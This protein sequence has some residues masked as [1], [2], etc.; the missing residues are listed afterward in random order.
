[1]SDPDYAPDVDLLEP[2]DLPDWVQRPAPRTHRVSAVIVSH[3]GAA[4]LPATL[5]TLAAQ[6][7]PPQDVVGVDTGSVDASAVLLAGSLGEERV[8]RLGADVPFGSA[9]RAGVDAL[10]ARASE[11]EPVADDV[12]EWIWLLHD[13]SAPDPACLE[14]LLEG[15]DAH[16]RAAVIGAKALGWHD[17][18]LLF[19]VGFSVTGSGRRHTGLE[20]REHDQGQHDDR[21]A[22]LAVGSAGMLIRR[23]VWQ[24]LDGFDPA[25]PIFRDDLDL[26]WRAYR[27]G[28]EVRVVPA[29]VVHHREASF[30]GR[31]ISAS[32]RT[33]GGDSSRPTRMHRADRRSALHVLLTHTPAWRLPL[34]LLRL[35]LGTGLRALLYLIGKD[36]PRAADELGA[37]AAL[38]SHPG[39]L[40]ASR[41]AAA[42]L[43]EPGS[44]VRDLRP[45]A[46]TMARAAL[47]AMGGMITSSAAAAESGPQD[48]DDFPDDSRPG[49]LRRTLARPGVWLPLLLVAVMLLV[50]RSLWLGQGVLL[51]GAL[52]PAPQGAADLWQAYVA[53]WHE[54]G[55][56]SAVNAPPWIAVLAAAATVLFGKAPLAVDLLVLLASAAAAVSAYLAVRGL[57]ASR[58]V[59]VW[60][61]AAYGLLPAVM[62][63]VATGRLGV[64]G[65][66]ILLPPTM[67]VLAR[68]AG[69]G[70]GLPAA[71]ARTPW[72]AGLL[73]AGLAACAP[74]LWVLAAVVA[75]LASVLWLRRGGGRRIAA[76][77]IA[78]LTP[79]VLLVPW[80]LD[81]LR[82]PALLL[83]EPGLALPGAPA[84]P[85]HLAALDP[86]GGGTPPWLYAGL[87]AVA[88]LCCL[89]IDRARATWGLWAVGL[90]ALALAVAQSRVF[91]E[92]AGAG[93]PVPSW[94]GAT[95]LVLGATCVLVVALTADGL[96][97]RIGGATFGWRQ[98]GALVLAIVAGLTP[99]VAAA[100]Y[101]VGFDGPLRRGS[102]DLL[103]A[104]VAEESSGP[105]QTRSLILGRDASGRITYTVVSGAGLQ[106]PDADLV[107]P[108]ADWAGLSELVSQM[109]AGRGGDE[110]RGLATYAI[111]YVLL[112]DAGELGD[113]LVA[114]LDSEPGLR[115]LSSPPSGALWRVAGTTSLIRVIA[116]G[117]S[118]VPAPGGAVPAGSGPRTLVLAQR[119][120]AGWQARA[121]EEVLVAETVEEPQS[122]WSQ[123]FALPA[124]V[125]QVTVEYDDST[126]A[127]WLWLQL[128]ALVVV[129]V[130]ALPTRAPRDPDA[131]DVD[132][133]GGTGSA[134]S[135]FAGVRA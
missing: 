32:R 92:P 7:R 51:G 71:T 94:P 55:P 120:D 63:A 35:V 79:L 57:L 5:T 93:G 14:R 39:R 76:L 75:V 11:Q 40:L 107:P 131:E 29:A 108:A 31:R 44:C 38:L 13:D 50:T 125:E 52:L 117:E 62:T 10:A 36:L 126:R 91:T 49:V 114:A 116:P 127:T 43:P 9:V 30:H 82:S 23:D 69:V 85:L 18:R 61:A 22:V 16:R 54:V 56:G 97:E 104:Y 72:L 87:V 115:R 41:R 2:D 123:G 119:A 28:H 24:E 122:A 47:E 88:V 25:L 101:I 21:S 68:C 103:P 90:G 106:I 105:A 133:D 17:R 118:P 8:L 46:R 132:A 3:N 27:A 135:E 81:L 74:M 124:D 26:C 130:L 53:G 99:V 33:S 1:M 34:T 58:P 66:A 19:E 70:G 37:L 112:T 20:R 110:V 96:R 64:L 73:L 78:V 100:A 129:L 134:A 67:R 83:D 98:P 86:G 42:R 84:A 113:P 109:A 65:A 6:T 45:R 59:R 80:S 111:G 121:G 15:A 60:L 48:E 128:I 12:V 4:W 95:T 89:R 77:A 102:P